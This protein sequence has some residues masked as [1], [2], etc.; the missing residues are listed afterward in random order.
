[1]TFSVEKKFAD[2]QPISVRNAALLLREAA[3]EKDAA[4]DH[5]IAA[6]EVLQAA[7]ERR[8]KAN[9]AYTR[10]EYLLKLS[11]LQPNGGEA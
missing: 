8:D 5:A 11:A 10:A 2:L 6:G 3:K 7:E 4:I 1:M 9:E